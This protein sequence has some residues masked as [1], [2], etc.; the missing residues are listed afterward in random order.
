LGHAGGEKL[1]QEAVQK[2][3]AN[4]SFRNA[5]PR[6]SKRNLA[7]ITGWRMTEEDTTLISSLDM[8]RHMCRRAGMHH[9][10]Q[11]HTYVHTY[12]HTYIHTHI[13]H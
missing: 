8:P 4:G 13:I 7:S 12:I 5:K 6:F 2:L 11:K 1:R 3:L 10:T 9:H